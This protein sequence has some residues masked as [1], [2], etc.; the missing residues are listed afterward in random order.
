MISSRTP[1]GTPHRCP[2]C[3]KES[4]VENSYP[5]GDSCCPRCG[6]LLWWFRD[7][8]SHHSDIAIEQITLESSF[9]TDSLDVVELVMEIEEKFDITITDEEAEQLK[10]VADLIRFIRQRKNER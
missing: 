4:T 2:V 3:G 5:T 1:E 7:R 10:T 8:L 6:Q 9:V